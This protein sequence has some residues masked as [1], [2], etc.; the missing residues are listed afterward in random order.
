MR[1]LVAMFVALV[2]RDAHPD[3]QNV[4]QI[5]NGVIAVALMD[6]LTRS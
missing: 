6:T 2:V 5:A 1:S 3:N 4:S